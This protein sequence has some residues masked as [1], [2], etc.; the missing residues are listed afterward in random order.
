MKASFYD[1]A[2]FSYEDYWK[3]RIYENASE[4]IAVNRLLK[5][6]KFETAADIGG[7]F[8][9]LTKVISKY[10]KNTRLVEP[11]E[12]MRETAKKYLDKSNIAIT[13][14][15][16]EETGLSTNSLD[17]YT[18]FRVFH[19]IPELQPTFTEMKRVIK[20]NGL[21][22][23]EFANS[24]NL[25]SRIRNFLNGRSIHYSP[26]EMRSNKNIKN[27]TIQFVNHHPENVMKIIKINGFKIEKVLSVS[28]FRL[29]ALKKF[30][31]LK[32]LLVLELISQPILSQWYFGPSIFVLARKV[33]K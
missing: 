22:L 25:K 6:Q 29:N 19:H 11:S 26:I 13:P 12:K 24:L 16:T 17:L 20:P 1:D 10:A 4:E 32:I 2:E 30:V 7:G 31:P 8:G 18:C 28:N 9:R 15:T 5:K 14:G 27:K 33:D 23:L 21:L 3:N